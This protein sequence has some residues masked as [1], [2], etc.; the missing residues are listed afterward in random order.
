MTLKLMMKRSYKRKKG[1]V[2]S[3]KVTADGIQFASGLEKYMYLTF[4]LSVMNDALMEKECIKI[5]VIVRF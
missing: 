2:Q 3:K 5:E 1:P 4:R